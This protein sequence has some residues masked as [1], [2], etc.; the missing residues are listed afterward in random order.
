MKQQ[1]IKKQIIIQKKGLTK[2]HEVKI[3]E[4]TVQRAKAF[5]FQDNQ[6]KE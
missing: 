2:K 4:R 6:S 5:L 3:K 1:R